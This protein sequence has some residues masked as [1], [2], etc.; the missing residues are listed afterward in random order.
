VSKY[1]YEL[2]EHP[3][4][5][6]VTTA[7]SELRID[8]DAQRMLNEQRA[9]KIADN[10]V[11]EA[12][13]SLVISRRPD[14]ST[15]IVDGQHRWRVCQLVGI[16]KIACEIH[17]GLTQQQEAILFLIKNRES[18]KPNAYDE[19]RVGLTGQLP[20]FVDTDEV[21]RAHGLKM[22]ATSTN[23]IGAVAGVLRITENYGP[24]IL[25]RTLTIAEMA[26][27]RSAGTW[28]GMLLGGIG[29]FLHKYGD[30]VNDVELAKKIAKVGLAQIWIQ[31]VI[32]VASMGGTQQT[33]T[34]GRLSAAC[35]LIIQAWN[36]GRRNKKI[37]V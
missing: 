8:P 10:L 26:W 35:T 6:G 34:G 14:R 29:L 22:G 5:Y 23:S 37:V 9:Q 36:S 25:D 31:R 24:E 30:L 33:G 21:L 18:A 13:G 2:P 3:V 7:I 4:Q 15:Y 16:E 28:D 12:L 20:L 1:S 17:D 19:Y 32:S 27:G 11:R